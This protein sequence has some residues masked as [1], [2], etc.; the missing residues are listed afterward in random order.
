MKFGIG[1][2]PRRNLLIGTAAF[3]K[4]L[5]IFPNDQARE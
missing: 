5:F 3:E 1:Q 4:A 2:P